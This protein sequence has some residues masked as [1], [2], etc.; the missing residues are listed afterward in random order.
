MNK[1]NRN[2]LIDTKNNLMV[3]RSGG[4]GTVSEEGDGIK[5]Q[6]LPVL[7]EM[8]NWHKDQYIKLGSRKKPSKG[9]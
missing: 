3:A 7:S 5:K 2:K 1:Q 4:L 6:K 9:Y 8:F